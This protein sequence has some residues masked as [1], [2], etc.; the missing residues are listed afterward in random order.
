[1]A[2]IFLVVNDAFFKGLTEE[3]QAILKRSALVACLCGRG[4]QEMNSAMGVSKL[5]EQGMEV[6]SPT[7]AERAQFKKLTQGP[8]I[9][10][11]KGQVDPLWIEKVQ[12]AVK[13][14]E[15]EM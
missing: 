7:S 9:E 6:Y 14:A 15:A 8:V 5:K 3:Q 11:M 4:I 10:W 1:M 2:L 12:A 13:E